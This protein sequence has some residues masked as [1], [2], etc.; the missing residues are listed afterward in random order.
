MLSPREALVACGVFEMER[1]GGELRVLRRETLAVLE[2]SR[3]YVRR[4]MRLIAADSFR[5]EG[6]ALDAL[7]EPLEPLRDPRGAAP[8]GRASPVR[9]D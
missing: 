5:V 2:P 1:P 9:E 3:D 8:G 6:P 4:N 7:L